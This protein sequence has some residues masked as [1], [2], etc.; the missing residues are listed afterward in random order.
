MRL[1]RR[2]RPSTTTSN[3]EPTF[4]PVA[5][6]AAFGRRNPKLLPHLAILT[7]IK[8]LSE[9]HAPTTIYNVYSRRPLVQP[10]VPHGFACGGF[11]SRCGCPVEPLACAGDFRLV[12]DR[13]GSKR[14]DRIEQIASKRRERIVDAR[15]NGG[16]DRAR[17]QPV[18]FEPAQ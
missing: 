14:G 10:L 13:P 9:A 12:A 15:R 4:S 11:R 8:L 16:I 5:A 3:S 7:F 1:R 18:A 17:D 2:S 6:T